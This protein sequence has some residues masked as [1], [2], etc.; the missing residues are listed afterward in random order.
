MR[1]IRRALLI[2]IMAMASACGRGSSGGDDGPPPGPPAPPLPSITGPASTLATAFLNI[3]FAPLQFQ[4]TGTGTLTWSANPAFLPPGITFSSTGVYSGT[5]TVPGSYVWD[6][7]LTDVNGSDTAP[8][9]QTVSTICEEVE[10]NNTP[11]QATPKPPGIPASGDLG[12]NDVDYWSFAA[13]AGQVLEFELLGV[14]R[15][16]AAWDAGGALPKLSVYAP[17]G[18]SFLIGHDAFLLPDPG[19]VVGWDWGFHDMDIPRFRI[20]QNGTYYVRLE[21]DIAGTD[22]GTYLLR[23]NPLSLGTIQVESESNNTFGTADAITPGTIRG[24]RVDGDDD[25]F[26]ITI[27]GP[28]IVYFEITAYRNGVFGVGGVPDDDYFDPRLALVDSDQATFLAINDDAWFFYDSAI[29][30]LITDPGTY[31]L[32]VTETGFLCAGDGEYYLTYTETSIGGTESEGN[33]TTGTADPIAYDD[34]VSGTC[35]TTTGDLDYFSFSGVAGDMVRVLWFDDRNHLDAADI[36]FATVVGSDGVTPVG[37]VFTR[38]DNAA[39]RGMNCLRLILPSTGTFYVVVF[40][41]T[42]DTDYAFQL[43]RFKDA[44]FETENNDTPNGA[45]PLAAFGPG[46]AAG[47]IGTNGD[48]DNYLI[49]VNQGD[50]VVLSIYAASGALSDGFASFSNYGSDLLPNVRILNVTPDAE[51]PYDGLNLSG[52][53]ITNGLATIELVFIAPATAGFIVE[54]TASDGTGGANHLYII[55]RR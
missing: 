39:Q 43:V 54:V 8:F 49:L 21:P 13:T 16:Y 50:V 30:Y 28:T 34:V 44:T 18:T 12:P 3:P 4:G 25:V 55:E 10:S 29:H 42:L 26:S 46:R 38:A 11:G 37:G 47:V 52:E 22:G 32:I 17:N 6:V 5:P 36:V 51:T 53:S 33:D 15:Q 23:I 35:G 27:T 2:S 20:P 7:T 14:R 24:T 9:E 1:H 48:V 41:N 40:G 19:L 31:Y 45:D